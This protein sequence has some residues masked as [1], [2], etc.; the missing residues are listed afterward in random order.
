MDLGGNGDVEARHTG[1]TEDASAAAADD[2][3]A[4]AAHTAEMDRSVIE[5]H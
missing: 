2:D 5:G 3:A 1:S 4:L